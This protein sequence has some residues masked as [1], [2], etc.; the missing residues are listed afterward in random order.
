MKKHLIALAAVCLL[1][2]AGCGSAALPNHDDSSLPEPPF[3]F[4]P[5]PAS[6]EDSVPEPPFEFTPKPASTP[7]PTSMP[8]PVPTPV[9]TPAPTVEPAA[10]PTAITE[11]CFIC[12]GTKVCN[13]C[14][15]DGINYDR[16]CIGC[17]YQEPVGAC[18]Y[19]RGTGVIIIEPARTPAPGDCHICGG[20]GDCNICG[21]IGHYHYDNYG[22][23]G[24]IECD[25]CDGSGDCKYCNGTGKE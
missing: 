10:V 3:E 18:F 9:P 4:T 11:T 17:L 5:K 23:Y 2:L 1:L 13:M 7:A 19:C 20:S 22:D 25:P 6:T 14:G 24:E 15:G 8:T 21:G 16:T 12:N